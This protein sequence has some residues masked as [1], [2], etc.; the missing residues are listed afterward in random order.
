MSCKPDGHWGALKAKSSANRRKIELYTL[1]TFVQTKCKT[2]MAENPAKKHLTRDIDEVL[3]ITD[4]V[5]REDLVY[6]MAEWKRL[7]PEKRCK[8]CIK[9][10]ERQKKGRY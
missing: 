1:I 10:W 8:R 5:R 9:E 2:K 6:D 7:S 3:C 4:N